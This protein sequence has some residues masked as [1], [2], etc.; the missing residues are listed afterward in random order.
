MNSDS[1]QPLSS[2]VSLSGTI[3]GMG[4][5]EV[6]ELLLEQK[7]VPGPPFLTHRW[8]PNIEWT[9][10]RAPLDLPDGE[11]SVTTAQGHCFRATRVNGFWIHRDPED[12]PPTTPEIDSCESP[13]SGS[14]SR[15]RA[16]NLAQAVLQFDQR[17][18][19]SVLVFAALIT[20]ALPTN[21]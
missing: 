5:N 10:L 21:R 8:P 13:V 3:R 15:R 20:Y 9:L 7:P 18:A 6:C 19:I 12:S 2:A 11:Y 16:R 14:E 1:I 17:Y 4:R